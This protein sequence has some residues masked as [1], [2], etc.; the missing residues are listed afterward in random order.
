MDKPIFLPAW[1]PRAIAWRCLNWLHHLLENKQWRGAHRL[2]K[3]KRGDWM[4]NYYVSVPYLSHHRIWVCPQHYMDDLVVE[5]QIYEG[6]EQRLIVNFVR[7][8]Y[9]YIDI[10]ANIGLHLI[11][12][13]SH[14]VS[15]NQIFWA[16]EPEVANFEVISK[17]VEAN[18]LKGVSLFPMALGEKA[19]QA[20]FFVSLGR[21]KGAH[22]LVGLKSELPQQTVMVDVKSLDE[23]SSP[24]FEKPFFLKIDVEGSEI[25][26]LRGAS[27]TL[28]QASHVAIL[29]EVL[30]QTLGYGGHTTTE[31]AELL[32]A[33][34]FVFYQLDNA[35][36]LTPVE[37]TPQTAGNILAI[38]A[39]AWQEYLDT[40]GETL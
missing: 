20:K 11:A 15:P 17:N 34:D 38:K 32:R 3:L 22:S 28:R 4:S 21:N 19:G 9:S 39:P 26:V 40:Y 33:L 8:G 29:M 12:A 24:L 31:L 6:L 27:D 2:K 35:N 30:P 7:L 10:G 25:A 23:L 14:Q 37:I 1:S 36:R 13:A 18:D 5:G 16:F